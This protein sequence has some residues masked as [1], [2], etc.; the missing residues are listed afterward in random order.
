MASPPITGTAIAWYGFAPRKLMME[1]IVVL[2]L[3]LTIVGVD[4]TVRWIESIS[5][6]GPSEWE[7][8]ETLAN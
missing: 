1:S 3:A 5:E 8:H 6:F 7:S 4:L 2:M